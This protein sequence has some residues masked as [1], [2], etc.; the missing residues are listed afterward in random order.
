MVAGRR[1]DYIG[2]DVDD[3]QYWSMTIYSKSGCSFWH[4]CYALLAQ[5]GKVL[6]DRR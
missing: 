3:V 2:S 4:R 5:N 1:E 6:H